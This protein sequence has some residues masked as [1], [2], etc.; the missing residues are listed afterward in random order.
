MTAIPKNLTQMFNKKQSKK[1]TLVL[2]LDE[3]LIYSVSTSNILTVNKLKKMDNLLFHYFENCNHIFVYYRPHITYFLQE[4]SKYFDICIFTNGSKT[5]TNMVVT[6]INSMTSNTYIS[7]WY[8]RT[9][10]YPF[11]KYISL[12]EN[13]DTSTVIIIDDNDKIWKDDYK[14]VISIKKFYGP[15]DKNYIFDDELLFLTHILTSLIKINFSTVR[16]LVPIIN[17][18]CI[19]KETFQK[20][21]YDYKI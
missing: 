14:N 6:M 4:M 16:N 17:S 20:N 18:H 5:Y 19:S 21:L 2:D 7:R 3:T 10:D 11:Y 13:I 1:Y 15:I 8:S 12:I 9:G